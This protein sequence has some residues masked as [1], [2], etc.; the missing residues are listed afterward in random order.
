MRWAF[1]LVIILAIATMSLAS[2]Q[3]SRENSTL[4]GTGRPGVDGAGETGPV[5]GA[6]YDRAIAPYVAKARASY[7]AAKKRFLTGLPP[8]YTFSVWIRLQQNDKKN[9]MLA[10]DVFV[11]VETIRDG[12]VTGRIANIPRERYELSPRPTNIRAEIRDSQLDYSSPRRIGRRQLR[13]QIPR[14]R[15][16]T[17][18]GLIMRWSEPPPPYVD[19]QMIKTVSTAANFG[20]SGGRSACSH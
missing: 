14:K 15:V 18:I 9:R 6:A 19:V 20:F 10:E 16:E 12:K 1:L 5:D 7:P 13:R 2:A 4:K 17:T 3:S 8:G 11:V